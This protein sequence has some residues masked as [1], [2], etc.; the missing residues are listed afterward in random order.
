[1]VKINDRYY[2]NEWIKT[3]NVEVKKGEI[4]LE[5]RKR[6]EPQKLKPNVNQVI[7]VHPSTG[8]HVLWYYN[9]NQHG[10]V[11]SCTKKEMQ[12][13]W[14]I[15]LKYLRTSSTWR[16]LQ[17]YL[18]YTHSIFSFALTF[19]SSKCWTFMFKCRKSFNGLS[20]AHNL[21]F[22]VIGY[23]PYR[24]LVQAMN[25]GSLLALLLTKCPITWQIINWAMSRPFTCPKS[26][27]ILHFLQIYKM[28][29]RKIKM[30]N[31][32]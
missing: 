29:R 15:S 25:S 16:F 12:I 27:A 32:S 19:N 14:S 18:L 4:L 23:Y 7:V 6:R 22:E 31:V 5:E 9:N 21:I 11:T 8:A 26:E 30:I 10:Q 13:K 20:K 17:S 28:V 1:M 2:G 3:N 24:H